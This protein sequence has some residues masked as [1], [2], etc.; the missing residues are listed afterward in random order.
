M[1]FRSPGAAFDLAL[2]PSKS[3]WTTQHEALL[4]P[5][6]DLPL[7]LRLLAPP[8]GVGAPVDERRAAAP[9]VAL[10]ALW[11][12]GEGARA[13]M[14]ISL[15]RARELLGA[16][17]AKLSDQEVERLRHELREL[18]RLHIRL[19]DQAQRNEVGQAERGVA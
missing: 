10:H 4:P 18:A 15:E 14:A 5:A 6:L 9:V 7:R 13:L 17:G 8:R 2:R 12:E 1:A 3:C 11:G 19:Y 16:E